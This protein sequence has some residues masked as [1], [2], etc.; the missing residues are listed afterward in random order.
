MNYEPY[1]VEIKEPIVV[2]NGTLFKNE[3]KIHINT[4]PKQITIGDKVFHEYDDKKAYG[5]VVN[6]DRELIEVDFTTELSSEPK[7]EKFREGFW[8]KVI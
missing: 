8:K 4:D 5:T 2:F 1:Q 7:T 6:I 3:E